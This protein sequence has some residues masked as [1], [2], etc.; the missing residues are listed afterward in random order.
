M[1][2]AQNGF[3]LQR[4]GVILQWINLHQFQANGFH[5]RLRK[6]PIYSMHPLKHLK[7]GETRQ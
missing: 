4:H 1:H 6:F 3:V 5:N 7:D 2:S